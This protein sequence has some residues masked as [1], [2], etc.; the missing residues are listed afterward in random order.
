VPRSDRHITRFRHPPHL[1]DILQ[2]AA[3]VLGVKI[4]TGLSFE[5][6]SEETKALLRLNKDPAK[7]SDIVFAA[8]KGALPPA[9]AGMFK[10][11]LPGTKRWA[12]EMN[13]YMAPLM[14]TWLVGPATVLE[15]EVQLP[16]R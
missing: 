3:Q 13:A 2:Y 16:G 5:E 9:V 12:C 14:T 10:A 4:A 15:G 7:V 11:L 1:I 8:M 6:L